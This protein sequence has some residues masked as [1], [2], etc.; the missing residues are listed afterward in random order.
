MYSR[1]LCDELIEKLANME[2]AQQPM[3]PGSGGLVPGGAQDPSMGG[4]EAPAA[5]GPKQ[6]KVK[7]EQLYE[8]MLKMTGRIADMSA[9]LG[10]SGQPTQSMEQM[11]KE[12]QAEM[13]GE[14]Q[15]AMDPSMQQSPM[16][17]QA[18]PMDPSMQ[19]GLQPQASLR[20]GVEELLKKKAVAA[21]GAG[22]TAHMVGSMAGPAVN[23]AQNIGSRFRRWASGHHGKQR[24]LTKR[25][26]NRPASGPAGANLTGNEDIIPAH[27]RQRFTGPNKYR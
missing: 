19:G 26:L 17:M 27:F 10:Q 25:Q 15:P 14:A 20:L 24:V 16:P 6:P 18:P 4:G 13:Q 23:T 21:L 12:D 9:Q 22:L 8:R 11:V 2:M 5:A 1:E 3:M 7:P